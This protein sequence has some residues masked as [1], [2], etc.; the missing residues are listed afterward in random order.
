MK[1]KIIIIGGGYGGLLCGAILSKEGYHVKILEKHYVYGG[2]L[3]MFGWKGLQFETGMHIISGFEPNGVLR[4][5]YTYL[6]IFDRLNIR[7]ADNES[8]DLFH[9]AVDGRKYLL[10]KGREAFIRSLARYF[11]DEEANIRRYV[12]KIYE[13][14]DSIALFNLRFSNNSF[15]DH[16]DIMSISAGDFIAS[17]TKNK[18]L[19]AVL[20]WNNSLYAGV[21]DGTPAYIAIMIS[22]FYIEGS[23]RFV[24]GSKQLADA[25][26][27]MIREGGGEII[28][29]DGVE[30]ID[31]HDK[32]IRHVKTASGNIFT[33]DRYIS[34]IHPSMLFRIMDTRKIQRSYYQRIDN[35]PNS[36]SVF[37][38]FIKFKPKSFRY[39]NYNY[40]YQ[41]DYDTTWK[42]TDYT[43]ENWPQAGMFI[44]PPETGH[45]EWANKMIVNC[46][47][48]FETVKQWENTTV[49]RRGESYKAFKK[50]CEGKVL[51]MLEKIYP[52]F[53]STV[54]DVISSTPLT[55]RD[56]LNVKEG[57]AY[58]TIK[59]CRNPA[60]SHIS[61]HTKLS[62]LLFTGQNLNLH[63]ILG[64]A[65]TAIS[66]CGELVG[67][68]N[69][70]NKIHHCTPNSH[71]D[72]N[73]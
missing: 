51:D 44:T 1:E 22:K 20:A 25:L 62:N 55:I 27:T 32:Q 3:H 12:N 57:A 40:Y 2:G 16:S 15:Y 54:D 38:T 30:W 7:P 46:V 66:T 42:Y 33:A 35:I 21:K 11:P 9:L 24:G 47:M 65:L 72:N 28:T 61:V 58:G 71:T 39:F 64:V 13:I 68:E 36:Y 52:G 6:G 37:N 56:Y 67:M 63:G 53:H 49:G 23:G 59:D 4:K 19:Q 8:F 69:L 45:D 17:F 43:D 34:S 70:I 18:K 48:K 26:A 31:I 73:A 60:A 41:E 50:R 14:C 5:F 10:A 29:G